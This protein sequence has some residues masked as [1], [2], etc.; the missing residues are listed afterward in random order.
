VSQEEDRKMCHNSGNT[1]APYSKRSFSG[2][3]Y[4]TSSRAEKWEKQKRTGGLKKGGGADYDG[5]ARYL[6]QEWDGKGKH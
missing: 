4:E 6:C 3:T 1:G 5:A 2:T